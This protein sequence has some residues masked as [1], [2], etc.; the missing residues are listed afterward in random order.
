M[1]KKPRLVGILGLLLSAAAL[2]ACGSDG[3]RDADGGAGGSGTGG[4]AGSGGTGGVAGTGG[5]PP[6]VDCPLGIGPYPGSPCTAGMNCGGESLT[7]DCIASQW[8]NC[9]VLVCTYG[10]LN[11][12]PCMPG[13]TVP[14]GC[15]CSEVIIPPQTGSYCQCQ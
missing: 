7:C 9:R 3:H 2:I 13:V 15:N 12:F 11:Q 5:V 8:Q 10:T 14:Q 1:I 6:A 4:V